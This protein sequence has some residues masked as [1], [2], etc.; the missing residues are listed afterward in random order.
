MTAILNW[1]ETLAG[2]YAYALRMPRLIEQ[3]HTKESQ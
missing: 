2:R 3:S 1:I